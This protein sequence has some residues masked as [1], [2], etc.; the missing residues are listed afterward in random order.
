[1]LIL[2]PGHGRSLAS[3]RRLQRRERW[4]VGGAALAVALLAIAIV[5][6]LAGGGGKV[7]K[8]CIDVTFASSL[9]AQEVMGC[10][11][12]ARAICASAGTPSGYTGEA[13]R[14]IAARCRVIHLPVG[15]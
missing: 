15:T 10:G 8:G 14:L 11:A 9:G 12:S 5:V 4:F 13:G 1:M 6:S 7:G 2:P 3:P